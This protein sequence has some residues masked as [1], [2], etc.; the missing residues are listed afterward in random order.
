VALI[1]FGHGDL[2]HFYRAIANQIRDVL[3]DGAEV[4]LLQW[5]F[6][7]WLRALRAFACLACPSF[8]HSSSELRL[9][10][11]QKIKGACAPFEILAIYI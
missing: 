9:D 11:R 6:W 7:R 5:L 4:N 2:D 10:G 1:D 3:P 8:A